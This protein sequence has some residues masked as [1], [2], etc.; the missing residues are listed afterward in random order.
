MSAGW[1]A[2]LA[3]TGCL[4]GLVGIGIQTIRHEPKVAPAPE[5]VLEHSV[6]KIALVLFAY[7]DWLAGAVAPISLAGAYVLLSAIAWLRWRR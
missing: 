4:G 5:Q 7:L 1:V 6:L 3:L 2:S